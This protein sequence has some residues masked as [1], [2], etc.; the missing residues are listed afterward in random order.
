[1]LSLAYATAEE[2]VDLGAEDV[3]FIS[4]EDS[5]MGRPL[6]VLSH[7]VTGTTTI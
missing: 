3:L 2:A 1:M 7:D 4:D 6:V 5:S